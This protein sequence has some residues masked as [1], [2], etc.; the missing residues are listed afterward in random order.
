MTDEIEVLPVLPSLSFDETRAFYCD[1]LG[2]EVVY[3]SETRLILR[4]QEMELHFWKTDRRELCEASS[5]YLRGGRVDGL[6]EEFS[7]KA[8]PGLSDFAVRPW[9]M[10]EFYLHDPHGTLLTFARIP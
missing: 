9:N 3:G 6:F 4:R 5:C 10:K 2:F 7:E 8:V 1:R